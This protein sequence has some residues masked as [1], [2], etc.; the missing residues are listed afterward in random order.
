MIPV[1]ENWIK[2]AEKGVN[3][4]EREEG[5]RRK[6]IAIKISFQ[7]SFTEKGKSC[8]TILGGES[9]GAIRDKEAKE[10]PRSM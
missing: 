1:G 5:G 7:A 6:Y 10:L 2:K 9:T 3:A 4:R 8:L